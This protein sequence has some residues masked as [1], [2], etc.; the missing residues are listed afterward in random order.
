MKI[1]HIT[2][3]YT[4]SKVYSNLVHSLDNLNVEQ[5]IYTPI[6]SKDLVGSNHIDLKTK[7]A[8]ILYRP[9][10]NKTDRVFFNKKIKKIVADLVKN[11][12][13][14]HVNITHAHT[15]YS[16]GAVA[17]E[18]Y[19]TY[20]IPYIIAI[21]STDLNLFYKYA[22]HLRRLG[23]NILNNA[24]KVIFVSEIYKRRFFK[25][26]DE[27]YYEEKY[28][29]IPNGVDDFWIQ[30]SEQRKRNI[31]ETPQ[32]LYVGTFVKRK[33]IARLIRAVE[34]LNKEGTQCELN[35]V[36]EGGKE[37]R[38]II[39]L[40]KNIDFVSYHGKVNDKQELKKHYKK[41]DIF[42]MPSKAETFGL[43]Y[44]EAL[45]QGI[46]IVFAENEG[47]DGFYD[48]IGEAVN[49]FDVDSI[50]KGIKKIIENYSCYSF[51]L[52]EILKNHNWSEI[53]KIYL[54]IYNNAISK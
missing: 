14:R 19:K 1:L 37:E 8:E 4:G 40:S 53:A 10:L 42:A 35:L 27:S 24:L 12:Y 22:L 45:S 38:K 26:F 13:H 15:W 2:N 39:N 47:I 34:Y 5:K 31:D 44:I 7:N 29:V 49:C 32:L 23:I 18:L 48:N 33:N 36:G 28:L 54:S 9:I 20:N 51:K 43:V 41:A 6:R 50:A 25:L 52:E 17:Y 46:P 16:D 30:N 3:D 11:E 21:R